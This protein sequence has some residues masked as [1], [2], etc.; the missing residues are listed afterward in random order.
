MSCLC[1]PVASIVT[2]HGVEGG[3]L[4]GFKSR[5]NLNICYIKMYVYLYQQ[6]YI[7]KEPKPYQILVLYI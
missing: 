1:T 4:F 3:P 7:Y 2:S 6:P 5:A